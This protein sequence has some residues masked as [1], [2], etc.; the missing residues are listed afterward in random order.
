ML[1]KILPSF[2]SKEKGHKIY[3]DLPDKS[4]EEADF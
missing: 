4:L 2:P 1:V 3:Y